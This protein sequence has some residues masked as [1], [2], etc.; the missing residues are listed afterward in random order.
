RPQADLKDPRA[1]S[2][3]ILR[4]SW[5]MELPLTSSLPISTVPF[6]LG[7]TALARQ[8]R[9]KLQRQVPRTLA[10]QLGATPQDPYYMRP[11]ERRIGLMS[12][13][14]LSA[15]RIWA[16]T[17]STIRFQRSYLLTLEIIGGK[18]YVTYAPAGRPAQISA[19]EGNGAVAIFDVNGNL[20]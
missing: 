7:T 17:R 6:R 9:S 19:T 12:L 16:R 5:L 1:K 15:L 20:L 2:A 18:I 3:T 10:S 4:P 13:M 11:T 14:V 8:P